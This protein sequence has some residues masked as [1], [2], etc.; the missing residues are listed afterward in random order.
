MPSTPLRAELRLPAE[1]RLLRVARSFVREF[2]GLTGLPAP[3]G[4][5]L[6]LAL[7]EAIA[8]VIEHGLEPG[9]DAWLSV[10]AAATPHDLTVTLRD[11]GLPFDPTRAPAY[12]PP[13]SAADEP[14]LEGLGLHLMRRAVDELGWSYRGREGNELRLR[15]HLQPTGLPVERGPED[16]RAHRQQAPLAP[17][18][19]YDVRLLRPG[20]E[21]EVARC[22]YRAYGLTYTN[23]DLY[24]PERIA[25]MN[26]AGTLVSAVAVDASGAVVGHT[27]L[28]RPD[29]GR[30]AELGVA[31]V[32]PAHRGRTLLERMCALLF[33]EAARLGL[34][35]LFGQAVTTHTYSQ[36][37][38]LGLGFV[39]C[40]LALDAVPAPEFRRIDSGSATRRETFAVLFRHLAA[41]AG[42]VVHAPARHR[43]MIARLYAARS[44]PVD[45]A[46]G[47]AAPPAGTGALEV[48][49]LPNYGLGVIRVLRG[50][51][52]TAIELRRALL[53]LRRL[54]AATTVLLDLP[55]ADPST[56]DLCTAA[57][58][59]GF[60]F[61]GLGPASLPDG[62]A[63]RLQHLATPPDPA[64]I[65]LH[66][67]LSVALL[68]YAIAEHRRVAR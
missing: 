29:L 54:A 7:D 35:G 26:A 15:V 30:V 49:F 64:V 39:P 23:Y 53:D 32:D 48:R 40:A 24:Y 59:D 25:A 4:E 34:Y 10:S 14:T 65:K 22:I 45:F 56:P 6:T 38:A 41:P 58:E 8:N 1:T 61:I 18:Q 11:P 51:A 5:A 19:D 31:A 13:A 28:E 52:E 55:L 46:P 27:A 16:L 62:D 50:G 2:V 17:P 33:A 3:R 60:A 12:R 42:V 36:R 47:A 63:L 68:E 67:P 57:E 44:V 66:S 43:D 37:A 21:L 9:E 20:E